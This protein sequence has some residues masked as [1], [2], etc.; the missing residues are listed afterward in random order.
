MKG[1][2]RRQLTATDSNDSS[3]S[4][5]QDSERQAGRAAAAHA[6]QRSQRTA[7]ASGLP[8]ATQPCATVTIFPLVFHL[9]AARSPT[10][11]HPPASSLLPVA[12][13]ERAECDHSLLLSPSRAHEAYRGHEVSGLIR[14]TSPD[15]HPL[16]EKIRMAGISSTTRSSSRC[17][18]TLS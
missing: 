17:A 12:H 1:A 4:A 7:A 2:E 3:D 6:P 8:S 15:V 11:L 10:T 14:A 18:A 5:G 9:V 16:D 13:V